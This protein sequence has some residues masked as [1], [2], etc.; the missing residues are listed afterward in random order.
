MKQI[1]CTSL[2]KGILFIVNSLTFKTNNHT[3]VT[4]IILQSFHFFQTTLKGILYHFKT[5]QKFHEFR[6]FIKKTLNL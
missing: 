5:V 4:K 2:S 1:S 6:V 3:I